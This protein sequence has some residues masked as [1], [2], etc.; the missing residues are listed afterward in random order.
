MKKTLSIATSLL[1]LATSLLANHRSA[2]LPESIKP[3]SKVAYS[4]EYYT[5]QAKLWKLETSKNARNPDAWLNYFRA[6]RYANMVNRDGQPAFDLTAIVE[7]I[8]AALHNT[9]E[10]QFIS[11][12]NADWDERRFQFLLK[13]H[14]I[15]PQRTEIY[16]DLVTYHETRGEQSQ[17][18]FYLKK[19]FEAGEF[20]AELLAWNY[21]LLAS[22]EP[23]AILLTYGDNDTYPLW[24]LQSARGIRKD[25]KVLNINLLLLEE[26]RTKALLQLGLPAIDLSNCQDTKA[27][28]L[29]VMNAIMS[30]A[31]QP[32]YVANTMPEPVRQAF[33]DSLYLTGLAFRYAANAFDNLAFLKNNYENKFLLD[34]LRVDFSPDSVSS[35]LSGMNLQYLPAFLLLH[36]H[37]EASGEKFKAANLEPVMRRVA[38][39]GGRESELAAYLSTYTKD[40]YAVESA[41]SIRSLDKGLKK[42]NGNL[43]AFDTEV[44]NG[45]Y[46]A[47]LM[48][49]VKNKAFDLLAT[50]QAPRTDWRSLLPSTLKNLPDSEVFK[51]ANPDDPQAPIVN[52]SHEAA[53]QYCTWITKVYNASTDRKKAHKKVRFRLPTEAEWEIA[54]HAGRDAPYPWGGYYIRNNKGCYL[55]NYD[56]SA[57]ATCKDCPSTNNDRPDDGGYFT[58]KADSYFPNDFGLYNTSGNVAEMIDQPG[59]T[60]G[61]SW[62]EIPYYGQITS[63]NTFT[64]PAPFI[65][66]RVFMEVIE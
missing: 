51:N 26:Y 62:F 40:S 46:E 65:G 56:V 66:F 18:L 23:D 13:A 59:A 53:Q 63:R 64:K 11:F 54:A 10:Y 16:H 50:C 6:A 57:E 24:V 31:K 36:Q 48:D 37:Y 42:I 30:G 32:V 45:Q 61:G 15:A 8:P 22:V 28:Y 49:L 27:M 39:E 20:P 44:T 35:V 5:E 60:K 25:V 58:V 17:A 1:F 9:F 21:N 12:M 55:A 34:Y 2:A 14:E 38:K 7:K 4:F 29:L 19:L 43:F 47:F 52:I 33:G 3:I 41:I